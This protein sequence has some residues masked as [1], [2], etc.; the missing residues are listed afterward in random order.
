MIRPTDTVCQKPSRRMSE[1]SELKMGAI[2]LKWQPLPTEYEWGETRQAPF[3]KCNISRKHSPYLHTQQTWS[4][5]SIHLESC[6]WP[7][8]KHMDIFFF[9]LLLQ[10]P[11]CCAVITGSNIFFIFFTELCTYII[12]YFTISFLSSLMSLNV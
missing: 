3:A 1:I 4:N 7:N 5:T 8:D 9:L 10:S 11:P 2:Q 12:L 6:L